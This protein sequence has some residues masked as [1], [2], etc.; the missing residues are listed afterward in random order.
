MWLLTQQ[1]I[2]ERVVGDSYIKMGAFQGGGHHVSNFNTA[3]MLVSSGQAGQQTQRHH[4]GF[5]CLA[6]MPWSAAT[7]T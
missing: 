6:G 7:I 2:A 3:G 1:E 5:S 4:R